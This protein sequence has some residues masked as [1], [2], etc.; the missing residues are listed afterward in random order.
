MRLLFIASAVIFCIGVIYYAYHKFDGTLDKML[1]DLDRAS[2][3][4]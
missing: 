1:V 4:E 2:K 3:G